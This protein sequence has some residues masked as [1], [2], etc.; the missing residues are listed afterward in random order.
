MS[1]KNSDSVL[2]GQIG[3]SVWKLL[4]WKQLVFTDPYACCN[5]QHDGSEGKPAEEGQKERNPW[6]G[7]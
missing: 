2:V 4:W 6:S 1:E 5:L 7:R 3:G